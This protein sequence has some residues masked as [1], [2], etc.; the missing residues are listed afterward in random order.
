MDSFIAAK[1]SLRV[2]REKSF[3]RVHLRNNRGETFRYR[4]LIALSRLVFFTSSIKCALCRLWGGKFCLHLHVQENTMAI[5]REILFDK[6]IWETCSSHGNLGLASC[7]NREF[8]QYCRATNIGPVGRPRNSRNTI[9]WSLLLLLCCS[10]HYVVWA[11]DGG[12]GL[13]GVKTA[14]LPAMQFMFSP[15]LNWKERW[16]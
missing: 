7:I 9:Y 13:L 10:V 11:Y 4:E 8:L 16:D 2:E 6:N 5:K 12:A 15:L 14:T 1:N 3:A